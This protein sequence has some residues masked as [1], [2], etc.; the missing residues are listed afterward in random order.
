MLQTELFLEEE[1]LGAVGRGLMRIL[2][3]I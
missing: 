2:E 1:Q 3:K